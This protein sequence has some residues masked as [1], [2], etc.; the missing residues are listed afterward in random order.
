M[1][2]TRRAF[3]AGSLSIVAA[4]FMVPRSYA[5][6]TSSSLC[7]V[8]AWWT[9]TVSANLADSTAHWYYTWGPGH[10]WID[11]PGGCEFVP[12]IWGEKDLQK[13][14]LQQAQANGRYLLGFNEPDLA[15]QSNM[16]VTYAL[17]NWPKLQKTGLV[18]GAP[19]VSGSADIA[20][21]WLDQF[22]S[23]A[24]SH[25]YRVDFIPLHWY[26]SPALAKNYSTYAA[27]GALQAYLTAVYERYR[28][29]VWLTEFSLIAWS[30]SGGT[31]LDVAVQAEFLQ[32]AAAMMASLPWLE[33]WA[34]FSLPPF[35][36]SPAAS[37]YDAS[38]QVTGVGQT[39]RTLT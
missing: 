35:D 37:L 6:G 31:A 19:A 2:T 28:L 24:R 36:G 26:P 1:A 29:P 4:G 13:D 22:M 20:G 38:G 14:M 27:V 9:P 33:R 32:A 39:F 23:G 12:M 21:S 34:W 11:T 15:T 8:G 10:D 7:G 30:N 5:A 3:L 16:S 18:L 17:K 25:R